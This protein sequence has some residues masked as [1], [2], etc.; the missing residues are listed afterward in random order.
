VCVEGSTCVVWVTVCVGC[1]CVW[2]GLSWFVCVERVR[3]CVKRVI[4]MDVCMCDLVLRD[5][6]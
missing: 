2:G 1:V 3:V 5:I 4:H 6:L